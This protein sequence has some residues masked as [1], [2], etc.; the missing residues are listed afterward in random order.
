MTGGTNKENNLP[1]T[2]K[3]NAH[4]KNRQARTFTG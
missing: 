1:S 3:K 2:R 4:F